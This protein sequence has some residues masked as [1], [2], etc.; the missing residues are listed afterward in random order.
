[1]PAYE[2]RHAVAFQETSLVGNVYFSHYVLWQGHV[3]EHFLH[4]P[5]P[6]VVELLRRRE[7]AFFTANCSC[8]YRGDWGFSALDEVLVR[9]RL[10]KFR[11]GRMSLAF[12]Y[13]NAKAPDAI[14]AVGSQEVHCKARV[15]EGWVPAPFPA[16]LVLALKRFADTP[17]LQEALQDAL[18]FQKS[19]A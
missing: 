19:R 3:R 15:G 14:V 12:E 2:Y 16:P 7:V 17:E 18:D 6:A 1:M 9:M 5:A 8:E 10:V 4:E 11:G 13:A